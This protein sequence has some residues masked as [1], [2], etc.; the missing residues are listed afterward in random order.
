MCFYQPNP[1][2]CTCTFHQLI[3]PCPRATTYPPPEPTKNPNPLVKVCGVR[4]F[5][6]GVGMR[7]CQGCQ[8]KYAGMNI[9]GLGGVAIGRGGEVE[10]NVNLGTGYTGF[11]SWEWHAGQQDEQE[12][13]GRLKEKEKAGLTEFA[14]EGLMATATAPASISAS[15]SPTRTAFATDTGTGPEVGASYGFSLM[16]RRRG[17][18]MELR[19]VV[20][21][22]HPRSKRRMA[23]S[24][25]VPESTTE[26]AKGILTPMPTPSDLGNVTDKVESQGQRQQQGRFQEC[27]HAL[28]E[29][30]EHQESQLLLLRYDPALEATVES[31]P[32][33]FEHNITVATASKTA[34]EIRDEKRNADAEKNTEEVSDLLRIEETHALKVDNENQAGIDGRRGSMDDRVERL[35]MTLA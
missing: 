15:T 11:I 6:K 33:G 26:A 7:I 8:S 20:P 22:P 30:G 21:Y 16:A 27:G 10:Y 13:S 32:S 1:P 2:G 35:I 18:K 29:L 31:I 12:T 24:S 5:A 3:Q 28:V 14:M 25:P 34:A 19:R 4:E 17:P 23:V 9:M